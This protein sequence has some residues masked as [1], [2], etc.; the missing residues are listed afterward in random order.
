MIG[1][2]ID[3]FRFTTSAVNQTFTRKRWIET[4]TCQ[5][6]SC[7]K[8]WCQSCFVRLNHFAAQ[9]L[10]SL[11]HKKHENEYCYTFSCKILIS[12]TL[13]FRTLTF[14]LRLFF[15]L[16]ENGRSQCSR[17]M[18]QNTNVRNFL[19][20]CVFVFVK[21]SFYMAE[22][23]AQCLWHDM[24]SRSKIMNHNPWLHF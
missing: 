16:V 20:N 13:H 3:T 18:A 10:K 8:I 11:R 22:N 7:P 24:N 21:L 15:E 12:Q 9:C 1:Y 5:S 6:I 14:M 23:F 19:G 2:V 4:G 17:R